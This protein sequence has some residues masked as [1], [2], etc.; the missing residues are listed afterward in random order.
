[1]N[2]KKLLRRLTQGAVQNVAFDD[3]CG[4]AQGF[5][6]SLARVNGSH[7]IF[8]HPDA[9]ELLNLQNV[10]GEAKPYQIRQFL[11][12]VERYNLVLEDQE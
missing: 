12:L 10:N 1:M 4:L 3:L 6:F 2:R 8:I 7:R 5:G 9:P 11:R